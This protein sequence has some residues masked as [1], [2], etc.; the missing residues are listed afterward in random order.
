MSTGSSERSHWSR[1]VN[2]VSDWL[3]EICRPMGELVT[4]KHYDVEQIT[5]FTSSNIVLVYILEVVVV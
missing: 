4:V 1:N 3:R 2:L 5:S